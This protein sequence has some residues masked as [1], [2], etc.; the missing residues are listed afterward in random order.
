MK[1]IGRKLRITVRDLDVREV[2]HARKNGTSQ[3]IRADRRI[4]T[5]VIAVGRLG[6][7][8]VPLIGRVARSDDLGHQLECTRDDGAA[9][10][11]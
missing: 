10:L 3:E 9:G 6:S 7:V 5:P 11:S 4:I 2:L 1:T 8:D